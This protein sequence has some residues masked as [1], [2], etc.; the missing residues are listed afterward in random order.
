LLGLFGLTREEEPFPV[1]LGYVVVGELEKVETRVIG[2]SG[3][4]KV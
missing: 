2:V 1:C 3:W 4:G